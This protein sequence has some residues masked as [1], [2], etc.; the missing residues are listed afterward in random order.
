M[1]IHILYLDARRHFS[2]T[3]CEVYLSLTHGDHKIE[4]SSLILSNIKRRTAD[5]PLEIQFWNLVLLY[6]KPERAKTKRFLQRYIELHIYMSEFNMF[7]LMNKGIPHRSTEGL[8]FVA[9]HFCNPA[10]IFETI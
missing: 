6:V 4:L 8:F 5:I 2:V 9:F 7:R 3:I 1:D 10:S